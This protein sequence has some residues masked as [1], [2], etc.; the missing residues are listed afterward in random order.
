VTRLAE[1]SRL[2]LAHVISAVTFHHLPKSNASTSD[3]GKPFRMLTS[4]DKS[5]LRHCFA[6]VL[7]CSTTEPQLVGFS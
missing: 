4:V 1:N 6:L 5:L 3:T 2:S 7:Q